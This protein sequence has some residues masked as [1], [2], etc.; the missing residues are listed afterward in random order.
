M[1]QFQDGL[2]W[3]RASAKTL[4]HHLLCCEMGY[5]SLVDQARYFQIPVGNIKD[6]QAIHATDIFY[7]KYLTRNNFVTWCSTTKKPD[8][9]GRETD[10]QRFLVLLF[11]CD[12]HTVS[13]F[14]CLSEVSN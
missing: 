4:V 3:Q 8:L 9:G 11:F 5:Q 14:S 2:D 6:D 7:A 13:L 1:E 12:S 10:D